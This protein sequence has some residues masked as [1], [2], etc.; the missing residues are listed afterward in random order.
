MIQETAQE[1][2]WGPSEG[3]SCIRGLTL[4]QENL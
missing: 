1:N 2:V 4:M 3:F